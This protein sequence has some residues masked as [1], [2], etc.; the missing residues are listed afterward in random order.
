[1]LTINQRRQQTEAYVWNLI[2][3]KWN[4]IWNLSSHSKRIINRRLLL[5]ADELMKWHPRKSEYLFCNKKTCKYMKHFTSANRVWSITVLIS[6]LKCK[7]QE[8][9]FDYVDVKRGRG[10]VDE[11]VFFY[12]ILYKT[13]CKSFLSSK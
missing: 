9:L 2:R 3:L 1:M 8:F 11:K 6:F 4:T 5:S 12:F 7:K 13:F 10:K